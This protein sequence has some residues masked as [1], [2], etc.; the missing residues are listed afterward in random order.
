MGALNG[1]HPSRVVAFAYYCFRNNFSSVAKGTKMVNEGVNGLNDHHLTAG[2]PEPPK[3]ANGKVR[4]YSMRFCPY[5]ERAMIALE[6]KKIPFE[7]VNINLAVKPEWYSSKVNPL[8]KVPAIEHDGKIIY[9]SLVCVEYLDEVFNSGKKILPND[10]FEVA[11]HRMLIERLSALPT[12]LYP[13]YRNPSDPSAIEK[14]EQAFQLYEKLLHHDFF[15]GDTPGY[16]DY[17]IWPW[18][19]RLS[20]VDIISNG[21]VSVKSDKY[22]KFAAY[23]QRMEAVPEVKSVWLDGP[24]HLKFLKSRMEGKTNYNAINS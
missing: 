14:V 13:Y 7:T 16:V 8:S 12:S 11:K 18:V 15:A 24:T 20:A 4:L 21:H 17:M 6:V 9:E 2:A 19:E 23:I 3:L 1:F 22:P 5:A 10:P